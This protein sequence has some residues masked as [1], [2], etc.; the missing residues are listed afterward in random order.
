MSPSPRILLGIPAC[1]EARTIGSV[2]ARAR[3]YCSDIMVID[4]GSTDGT[5]DILSAC[6][7]QVR[8]HPENRG[9]GSSVRNLLEQARRQEFDWLITMD[10][11]D[12]H[13]PHE[14]PVFLGAISA[15][16]VDVI[17]GSRYLS[18]RHGRDVP[19]RDRQEINQALTG[20]LNRRCAFQ[21]TDAFCGFKAFRVAS[22]SVLP[23]DVDG[24]EFPLQFWVQAHVHGLR[25]MEVPV[26]MVYTGA[27]RSFGGL[28]DDPVRRHAL[29]METM[30]RELERWSLSPSGSRD[31]GLAPLAHM[32]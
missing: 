14:I 22:C 23:L 9:Y 20:E 8:R 16:R 18:P 30:C 24:Y 7:V 3:S 5:T 19:P 13:H 31:E 21:I 27:Q 1:N 2:L 4:D 29:Y 25:V 10:A 26:S 6:P 28:L 15:S 17:S 11:D 32:S 12:Q